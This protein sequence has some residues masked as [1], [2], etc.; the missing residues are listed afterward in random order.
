MADTVLITGASRG[1]GLEFAR[2]YASDG[3]RVHA[4]CR[5]PGKAGELQEISES[6]NGRV[7]VHALDVTDAG[8][9]QALASELDGE[10][11]DVLVNNAGVYGPERQPFGDIDD[12]EWM[13]VLRVNTVAPLKVS[14]AFVEHVARSRRK[15]VAVLSSLMGSIADNGSGGY[16]IYRSSKAAVNIVVKSMAVDLKSRGILAVVLHPGWVRT[17]MGGPSA[18]TSPEESV[19]GMRKVLDGLT[20][21]DSGRFFDFHG[22]ALPW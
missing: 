12:K 9:V 6:S 15:T 11:I 22:E 13:R 1:I 14:E 7:A 16:Y 21:A 3:W 20:P 10:N 18:T 2:Q 4:C 8:A 19:I 17:D 5:A